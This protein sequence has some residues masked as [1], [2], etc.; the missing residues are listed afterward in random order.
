MHCVVTSRPHNPSFGKGGVHFKAS[1]HQ[2]FTTMQVYTLNYLQKPV[3]CHIK[4]CQLTPLQPDE[5]VN[6][7][8][9]FWT[10]GSFVWRSSVLPSRERDIRVSF[11]MNSVLQHYQTVSSSSKSSLNIV[12]V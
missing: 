2:R 8:L 6:H 4:S 3:V 12:V 1:L 10:S 7:P 5:T 11:P 9:L